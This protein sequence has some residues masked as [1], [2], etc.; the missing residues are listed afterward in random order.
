MDIFEALYTTRAMRRVKPDPLPAEVQRSILDAAVRAPSAGDLQSW[1]FL[2][3]DDPAIKARL[4]PLYQDALTRLFAGPYKSHDGPRILASARYL[5]DH[6]ETYPLLMFAFS[7]DPSGASIFPAVWSAQLAA[8]AHGVGS[9]L[10]TVLG[11]YHP[12]ATMRILRVPKTEGWRPACMV[13]FGY[14]T[15]RWG[16]AVRQPAGQV[17]YRNQWGA[18]VGLDLI[19]PVWQ[20]RS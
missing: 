5:A 14:P 16:L 15:G 11:I 3:V 17:S 12:T 9:A 1:R 2:L 19:E 8:R 6:F 20:P 13:T 4:A 18:G 10:T 7:T